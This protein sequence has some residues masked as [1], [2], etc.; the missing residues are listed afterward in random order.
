MKK[1]K[2]GLTLIELAVVLV[3]IGIILGI[4]VSIIAILV[5]QAKQKDT[6]KIVHTICETVKAYAITNKTLP[7]DINSLGVKTTDP[8]GNDIV[9]QKMV[10][11][12]K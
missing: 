7:S 10:Q 4:G 12:M 2:K 9:I 11:I 3:I 5:K 1:D 6:K 8:Y